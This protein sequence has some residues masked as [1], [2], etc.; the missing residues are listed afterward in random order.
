MPLDTDQPTCRLDRQIQEVV[1]FCRPKS[2]DELNSLLDVYDS[3]LDAELRE[4]STKCWYYIML[5][6]MGTASVWASMSACRRGA[7]QAGSDTAFWEHARRRMNNMTPYMQN[8]VM[9]Q[10]K[11]AGIDTTGKVHMTGLG[12]P[13]NPDAWISGTDDIVAVCKKRNLSCEGHVNY[14][15]AEVPPQQVPLAEDLID[16]MVQLEREVNPDTDAK[17]RRDATELKRLRGLVVE[18]YGCKKKRA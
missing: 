13:D 8:L 3:E 7:R 18:K 14:Q 11:Q 9:K 5:R 10:A 6:E 2:S 17:C 1:A 15:G 4:D 16:E 12:A